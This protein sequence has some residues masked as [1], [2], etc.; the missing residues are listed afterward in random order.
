MLPAVNV[1]LSMKL[2]PPETFTLPVMLL[3][4]LTVSE[5]LPSFHSEP[6]PVTLPA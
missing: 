4:P 5:P 3:L 2:P 6:L 1:P